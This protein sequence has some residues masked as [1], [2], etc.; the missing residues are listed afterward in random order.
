MTELLAYT[1]ETLFLEIVAQ[2]REQGI[3]TQTQF[4]DLVVEIVEE[5]REL[6]EI[7][8]DDETEDLVEQMRGMWPDYQEALDLSAD[9]PVL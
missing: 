7:G 2:G 1:P 9:Q 4:D 8:D 5:H 6:A 3:T